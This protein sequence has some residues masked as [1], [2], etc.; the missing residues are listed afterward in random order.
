[1]T[2]TDKVFG[3]RNVGGE[4]D[5]GVAGL[6]EGP[7]RQ[8]V[9]GEPYGGGIGECAAVEGECEYDAL[10]DVSQ[11]YARLLGAAGIDT[12]EQLCRW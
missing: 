10:P 5:H 2:C 6:Q 8:L 12:V 7:G 4:S 9:D 1:M 11:A 3:N